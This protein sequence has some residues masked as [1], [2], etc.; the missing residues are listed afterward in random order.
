M[1]YVNVVYYVYDKDR[2]NC[3]VN[4]VFKLRAGESKYAVLSFCDN[5]QY[6]EI[7]V[8]DVY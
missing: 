4:D 7:K 8:F 1:N 5:Y 6:T 2:C 3:Q